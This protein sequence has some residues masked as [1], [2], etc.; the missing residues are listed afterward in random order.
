ME[1]P[2]IGKR[3]DVCNKKAIMAISRGEEALAL[4]C[5]EDALTMKEEHFDTHLNYLIYKWRNA[6]FSDYE[7]I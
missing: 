6:M 7:L 1:Q 3:T 5:W 2:V 4:K